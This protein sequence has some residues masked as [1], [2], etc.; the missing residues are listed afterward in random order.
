M[1]KFNN[2]LGESSFAYAALD[3]LGSLVVILDT[4]GRIIFFNKACEQTAGFT[5]RDIKGKYYWDALLEEEEKNLSKA[6]FLNLKSKDFPLNIENCWKTKSGSSRL[7]LLTI[8]NVTKEANTL[9]FLSGTDITDIKRMEKELLETNE[10]LSAIIHASPLA[11]IL[12]DQNFAVLSWNAAAERIFGWPEKEVLGKQPPMFQGEKKEW[13]HNIGQQVLKGRFFTGLECR[14]LRKDNKEIIISCSPAPVR[15][16]QGSVVGIMIVAANITEQKKAEE[17]LKYLSYNDM[18]TGLYNRAFFEEELKRLNTKE[19]LPLS[20]I[21][22]DANSLKLVNDTFGHQEGDRLLK[23][24]A[25]ILKKV[26]PQEAIICR[27][28]GDEFAI[29]LPKTKSEEAQMIC[30]RIKQACSM[31]KDSPVQPSISLGTATKEKSTDNMM[32]II[33]MAEDRMYHAKFIEEKM[34]RM[35]L[36]STLRK[37]LAEKT[38]KTEKH[39]ARLQ[40]Y[41]LQLGRALDLSEKELEELTLITALH[42]IGQVT[43]PD[44]IINKSGPLSQDEWEYIKNPAEHSYRILQAVPELAHI[45]EHILAHHERWD[46]KGY[47]HGLKG[48]QIPLLARITAIAD[49]YDA[50]VNGRHYKKPIGRQKA[51][52]ELQRCAGSQFDPHLVDLFIEAINKKKTTA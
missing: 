52:Q 16:Y 11:V 50:M 32:Q 4:E 17:Q 47:P 8:T 46:G 34:S 37:N 19:Q 38:G 40:E 29:L 26:C 24:I 12:M 3:N 44:N 33:K 31:C 10:K 13:F 5:Y 7:L 28:G 35:Q 48:E 51:I 41:A 18:L 45:A 49:A 9:Y 36:I 21:M 30:Q 14:C 2:L 20:F 39:L 15:N 25:A 1:D 22:G 6:F 27:W 43:V 42:D 23:N